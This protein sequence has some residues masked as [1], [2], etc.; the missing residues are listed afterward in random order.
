MLLFEF[1][2]LSLEGKSF[3]VVQLWIVWC[4]FDCFIIVSMRCLEVWLIFPIE[5]YIASVE[6]YRSIIRILLYRPIKVLLCI[7]L[8]IKVVVRQAPII[9]VHTRRVSIDCFFVVF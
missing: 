6:I 9:I 2:G 4:D 7:L 1:L 8:L 5:E 3:G